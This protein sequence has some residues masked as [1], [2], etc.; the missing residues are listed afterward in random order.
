MSSGLQGLPDRIGRYQ[1]KGLLGSGGLG[2]VVLGHDPVLNREV[3]LKLVE[4][5]AVDP[6][7][8]SEVRYMFHREARA[9][10]ALRHPGI[11]EVYD[12][13]GPDADL[14]YIA[15][16]RFDGPTLRAVLDETKRVE[17]A[18]AA[19]LG[20]ELAQALA[21]AHGDEI[22]HRDIKPENIF[23]LDTG[24]VVL[25]DFGIA[26]VFTGSGRL[27]NT[28]QFGATSVYGSPAY[29]A[30]EQLEGGSVGPRTDIHALGAV[31]YEM[32]TGQQAFDGPGID[33]IL[34]A[35][36][37]DAR[38]SLSGKSDAPEVMTGLVHRMLSKSPNDRPAD[39]N[40]VARVL[41]EALDALDISDPRM[42]LRD[43]G[44]HT[45]SI[46]AHEEEEEATEL[47]EAERPLGIRAQRKE[48]VLGRLATRGPLIF[49]MVGIALAMGT[50][51][52]MLM[53]LNDLPDTDEI[54]PGRVITTR[55]DVLPH[56]VD[57]KDVFILLEYPGHARIWVD[58]HE[59]GAWDDQVR[60][61]LPPGKHT[62]EVHFTTGVVRR[63]VLL[64][65]DT[66][67]VFEF[68]EPV[69]VAPQ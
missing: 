15:C 4:E 38:P 20:Y 46:H 54:F 6:E 68:E 2:R 16:E 29:M 17:P 50:G 49:A 45:A 8:L 36:L 9:T 14:M 23:W 13:S 57:G 69:D 30:P 52:Y 47:F 26:K 37:R 10:A 66:Q 19:A 51:T 34:E 53:R 55:P 44:D 12:Y 18:V 41:R 1:V 24:R 27:G 33:S 63:D 40:A 61:A 48:S 43:F 22:V 67:P 21:V 32:L 59:V 42:C 31:L 64:I 56:A 11:V 3:A 25:S 65:A 62:L 39:A 28:V 58:G 60:L 5:A 7:S 35:V